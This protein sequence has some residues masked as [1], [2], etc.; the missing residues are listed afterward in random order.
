MDLLG[1][2]LPFGAPYLKWI[3]SPP[4]ATS[5]DNSLMIHASDPQMRTNLLFQ[6]AVTHISLGSHVT[7]ICSQP[8]P[9]LP[10]H[11]HAMPRPQPQVMALLKM[12]YISNYSDLVK[13]LASI[14]NQAVLPEVLIVDD[15]TGYTAGSQ[16]EASQVHAVARLCALLK[17]SLH[18]IHAKQGIGKVY[19]SAN[20]NQQMISLSQISS[21]SMF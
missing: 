6:A 17:D 14:H 11:V 3:S 2:I 8:L 12:M 4:P 13:F 15:L 18:F 16:N 7:F 5:L 10:L 9:H 1:N 20:N 19:T 21:S